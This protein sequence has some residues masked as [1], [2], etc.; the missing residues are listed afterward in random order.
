MPPLRTLVITPSF[1]ITRNAI[2]RTNANDFDSG[3]TSQRFNRSARPFY[4]FT[5]KLEPLFKKEKEALDFFHAEHQ[6]GLSF[7]C[8]C[9]PYNTVENYQRFAYA[10][11]SMSQ[12]FLPNRY[13]GANSFSLQSRN[14]NTQA[15]SIW[16]TNAYSLMAT[17]GIIL[18]PSSPSSGHDLEAKY[19]CQYRLVFDPDGL[20]TSEWARGVY[21]TEFNLTEVFIFD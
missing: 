5:Y 19:S 12:F 1:D 20:K 21:R 15:T 16:A 7:M 2:T 8:E 17:P 10:T 3:G 18:F 4:Q 9:H 11:G 6:G 14:L 13:I